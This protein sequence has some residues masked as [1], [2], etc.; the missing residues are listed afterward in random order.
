MRL[1]LVVSDCVPLSPEALDIALTYRVSTYDAYY[2]ALAAQQH[3]P[4]ITADKRLIGGSQG[5]PFD[6]RYV[7]DV[8]F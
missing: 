2:L 5:T 8:I 7:A 3:A 6:V 4:L 1:S